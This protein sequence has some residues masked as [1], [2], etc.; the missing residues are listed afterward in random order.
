V[1]KKRL[2]IGG[3]VGVVVLAAI[4]SSMGNQGNTPAGTVPPP[5][6][7]SPTASTAAG[8]QAAASTPVP[9]TYKAGDRIKLGEEEFF[10]IVEVDPEVKPT[11]VFKPDAGNKWV[12]ALVEIEG[13]NPDGAT[14][15]PFYFKVRDAE[16]FE[17][18]FSAFGKE[19][20]LQS[21]NELQ[22]GKKVRGWVTFEIPIAS[23]GL[24][25]IYAPGIFTE[26]VEVSL[27]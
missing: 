3:V 15:N 27:D 25:L 6:G 26:P 1:S 16:G 17:F 14:Y 9:S 19:P 24:V 23:T 11:D 7:P 5:Q 20:M 22:P 10:A 18:T 2:I 8:S 21:G 12:A 4:G 13:I